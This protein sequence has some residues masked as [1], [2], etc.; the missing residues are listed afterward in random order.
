MAKDYAK[1]SCKQIVKYWAIKSVETNV[2]PTPQLVGPHGPLDF[3]LD[4]Q[5]GD[6]DHQDPSG[7][8]V[9]QDL[10]HK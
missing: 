6:L 8:L 2:K 5:V 4:L 10:E 3:L 1:Y 9:D 7:N